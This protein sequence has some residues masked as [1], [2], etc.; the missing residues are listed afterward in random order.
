MSCRCWRTAFTSSPG[1]GDSDRPL[2]GYDTRTLAGHVH[3]LLSD[4]GISR[5][6]LAA[7]DVGAW[8]AF[9]DALLFGAEISSLVL[10]DAGIPGITLPDHLP[11]S[12]ETAWKTWHFAFHAVPDL[13]EILIEGR[14]ESYLEWFLRQKT[15]N[16]ACYT[17][18]DIAEYLR[19][20]RAPG[21]GRL[22]GGACLLSCSGPLDAT[23]PRTDKPFPPDDACSG[24]V[25]RSGVHSRHGGRNRTVL[26]RRA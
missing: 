12:P 18:E 16:S 4:L 6:H 21:A 8:V 5:Y 26:R 23:E 3:A 10:M 2:D 15:V 22:A 11:T 20:L 13:P 24:F 19:I 14:E 1:Q 17:A 25:C 7:H 9:P